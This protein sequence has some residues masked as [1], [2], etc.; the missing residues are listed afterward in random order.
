MDEGSS[1]WARIAP[2]LL[3]ELLSPPKYGELLSGCWYEDLEWTTSLQP[4][5]LDSV[6]EAVDTD[7]TLCR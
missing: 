7:R 3:G 2:P 4:T 5:P 1:P 6:S